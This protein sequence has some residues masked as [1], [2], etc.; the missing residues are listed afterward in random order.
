RSLIGLSSKSKNKEIA[1][2]FIK[3][4]LTEEY[5]EKD[6]TGIPINKNVLK[7]KLNELKE[8]LDENFENTFTDAV[9]NVTKLKGIPLKDE[10]INEV[11]SLVEKY[12]G[13]S[14]PNEII[15]KVIDEM[16]AYVEGKAS[17]DET[18]TNIEKKLK[19]YLSE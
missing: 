17:M 16:V 1:K 18:I 11:M 10:E 2:D 5:Q 15:N 13:W 12:N 9:G 14:I 3:E 8:E 19:I 6:L 4:L 7:N